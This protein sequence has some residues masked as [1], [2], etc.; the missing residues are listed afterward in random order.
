MSSVPPFALLSGAFGAMASCLAKF[1]FSSD[2]FLTRYTLDK[3]NSYLAFPHCQVLVWTVR[4]LCFV[5][6]LLLNISMV[7]SFLEGMEESGSVAGT[8]MSNAANFA[9]SSILGFLLWEEEFSTMWL[10]GF[11]LVIMGTLLLSSVKAEVATLSNDSTKKK[12]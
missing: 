12:D 10:C 9:V 4:G 8:A 2:T 6:N 3:C 11:V 1:A 7:G 5:G